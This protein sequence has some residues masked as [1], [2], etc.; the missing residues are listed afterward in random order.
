MTPLVHRYWAGPS[1][2]AA[3]YTTRR[4]IEQL[5]ARVIDWDDTML[6]A[7][8]RRWLDLHSSAVE[9][10]QRSR[11]RANMARLWLLNRY[12]GWWLDHDVWLFEWP[13]ADGPVVASHGNGGWCTAAMRFPPRHPLLTR[14]IA[15][16]PGPGS[17]SVTAS[18]ERLLEQLSEPGDVTLVEFPCDAAG[19]RL[20]APVWAVHTWHTTTRLRRPA[21]RQRRRTRRR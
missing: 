13:D 15:A 11:H 6:P 16:I 12:G 9:P 18:G 21:G 17:D 4:L 3:A 19:T 10:A 8:C 7:D 2:P 5:D 14:T 20:D 1:E